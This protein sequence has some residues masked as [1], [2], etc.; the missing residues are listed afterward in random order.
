MQL[1]HSASKL[2]NLAMLYGT[3]LLS[4]PPMIVSLTQRICGFLS[5]TGRL[6]LNECGCTI[7]V[8]RMDGLNDQDEYEADIE[9]Q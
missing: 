7:G 9:N 2:F 3:V 8:K 4:M 6:R 5:G 1:C